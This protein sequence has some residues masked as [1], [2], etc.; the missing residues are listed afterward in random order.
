METLH[1]ADKLKKYEVVESYESF[2]GIYRHNH[3][4]GHCIGWTVTQVR[5]VKGKKYKLNLN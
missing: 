4:M 1:K 3:W 5:K 2:K